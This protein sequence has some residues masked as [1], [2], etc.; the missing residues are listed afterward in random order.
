[1]CQM[2]YEP[3]RPHLVCVTKGLGV[4]LACNAAEHKASDPTKKL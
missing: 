3:V 2:A 4:R 1:M